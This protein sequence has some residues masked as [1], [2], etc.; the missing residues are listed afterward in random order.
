MESAF[1]FLYRLDAGLA[2]MHS[3]RGLQGERVKT[4]NKERDISASVLWVERAYVNQ[5]PINAD[6]QCNLVI[7][8]SNPQSVKIE[9]RG[10]L[11]DGKKLNGSLKSTS[12]TTLLFN[13]TPP[14]KLV[15]FPIE[16]P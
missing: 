3:S 6:G 10:L 15:G 13:K 9:C 16:H 11:R 7:S 2:E 8:I 12:A 14:E 4:K 5:S 1:G